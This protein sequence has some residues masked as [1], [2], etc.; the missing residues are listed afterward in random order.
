MSGLINRIFSPKQKDEQF[1]RMMYPMLMGNI[2]V[3]IQNTEQYIS[4]GY[5][6]NA[7]V[8]SIIGRI[9]E[10]AARAIPVMYKVNNGKEYEKAKSILTGHLDSR[11]LYQARKYLKKSVDEIDGHPFLELLKQPN[12]DQSQSEYIKQLV[13]FILITG[14]SYEY[15][16][17]P[18]TG[19]EKG[20]PTAMYMLP[21]QY[22]QPYVDSKDY[23]YLIKQSIISSYRLTIRGAYEQ[24]PAEKV[25]HHVYESSYKYS[26]EGQE[27]QGITPLEAG[28]SPLQ[29]SNDAYTA[30]RMMLVNNGARGII[31]SN[32]DAQ[33][34]G[35]TM[36]QAQSLKDSYRQEYYGPQAANS[37][38]ITGAK[39][40][41]DAIGMTAQDMTLLEG[42]K[43]DLRA[44]CNIYKV[45]VQLFNDVS[46]TTDNN[47]KHYIKMMI[48]NAVIPRLN[49]IRDRWNHKIIPRYGD[50]Q[51]KFDWDLSVYSEL[52]EDIETLAN[53]LDKLPLTENEKRHWIDYDDFDNP[54]ADE[55][56]LPSS[57][58]ALS[59]MAYK[60]DAELPMTDDYLE[61]DDNE[62]KLKQV[63]QRGIDDA[64]DYPAFD[65]TKLALARVKSFQYRL[66]YGKFKGKEHDLD[67][68]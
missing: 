60:A 68:L 67:L 28:R 62:K 23:D 21:S 59:D 4:Q 8:Y 1:N 36:E 6:K 52:N 46:A 22:V 32:E 29:A 48:M 42:M 66:K 35:M 49:A 13:G 18:L 41:Y 27:F 63:Y 53:A 51:V 12:G 33:Q 47:V 50:K 34:T 14:N 5:Y 20:K 38:V 2:P 65:A 64:G 11:A 43:M 39:I 3:S 30:K 16:S 7:D 61:G 15:L 57:K 26:Y 31:S 45:P 44:L 56:Y 25:I 24:V 19:S 9:C 55:I 37:L 10:T 54:A 40:K 17:T 58:I